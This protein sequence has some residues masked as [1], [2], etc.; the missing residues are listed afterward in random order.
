[1]KHQHDEFVQRRGRLAAPFKAVRLNVFTTVNGIG[2]EYY[3]TPQQLIAAACAPPEVFALDRKGRHKGGVSSG[4]HAFSVNRVPGPKCPERKRLLWRMPPDIA[5]RMPGVR[6]LFPE[7]LPTFE[8]EQEYRERLQRARA[9]P[10]LRLVASNP[11]VR[12]GEFSDLFRPKLSLVRS[13]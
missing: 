2:I 11:H 13:V 1:V 5:I 7:G 3:G 4:G 9:R 10:A 12:R 8:S 6:E